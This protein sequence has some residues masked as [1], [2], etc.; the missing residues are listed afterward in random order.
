MKRIVIAG[1]LGS[2]TLIVWMVVVN[3]L[4]GFSAGLNMKRIDNEREVYETLR[5]NVPQ[6]GR[7]VINPDTTAE[8][9]F[10]EGEPVFSVLYGGMGHGSAGGH[11]IAGLV[12]MLIVPVTG[13]WLLSQSSDRVLSSYPRKVLYFFALG[14]LI[15]LF[16]DFNKFGI[17]GYPLRD[18][19]VLGLH[20]IVLWTIV[21][22]VIA[23]R[24]RPAGGYSLA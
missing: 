7:Y 6:P 4:L 15:A 1:L 9:R 5:D 16:S 17:G 14:L 12:V 11:A 21:G 22:L 8:G 18:T 19:L 20:D 10:L 3:G 24:I 2:L 23:W 13:A